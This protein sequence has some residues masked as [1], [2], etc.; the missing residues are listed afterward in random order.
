MSA[1]RLTHLFTNRVRPG[2][3]PIHK[4]V[5]DARRRLPGVRLSLHALDERILP[6]IT[7]FSLPAP[8]HGPAGITRGPDGNIWFAE[9]DALAGN[10][11]G[12]ISLSGQITEFATGITSGSQPFDITVGPDGNLWFT[13]TADQIG[14]I[15]PT[16]QVTEF[17]TGITAGSQPSG[18]VAGP[19]GNIWFTEPLGPNSVGA[20]ARITPTGV[21]TEFR[22]GLTH[23]AE[24]FEITVG[25]D[26]NLW[27]TELLGGVGRIT[28]T[29]VIT[30]FRAGITPG[31][32]PDGITA[33]PDGN[34]WFTEF[35]GKISRITTAGQVTEFSAGLTAGGSPSG[36]TS[37][38]D[39]NLWFTESNGSR[40]GSINT[41]G[42]IT[43]FSGG[44][45][46]G[47]SPFEITTGPGGALWF[48]EL[49][50][51]R[52]A[53]FGLAPLIT[54]VVINGGA[55]QRSMVTQLQ[56]AFD[57]H[58]ILP[59]NAADAF[60]LVRQSDGTV[61]T[62]RAIVDDSTAAGTIVMLQFA[63]AATEGRS[64]ADG[65]Y[66]LTAVAGQI[67]GK[68]GALDGNGDGIGGD[69]FVF[70]GNT[71]TNTLFR[72]FGDANGDGAVAANDFVP[73]R[74]SFNGVNAI[75]D[76]NGDG[77]VSANDFVEF[78]NRFNTS[79]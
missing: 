17:A 77:F 10:R 25:S 33:G 55:A 69:D 45:T 65:R 50:G 51:N 71:A 41:E 59:D 13:E 6:S 18:I 3:R 63:G 29:G 44:I 4:F 76:F 64:L 5:D 40:I 35:G 58:V 38:T 20:I 61:V 42:Q 28:T 8:N 24:P 31:F 12:R 36:I 22:T 2:R 23:S 75:F 53:R 43:E 27:F 54:S 15:S 73:F 67:S 11:I 57:Q 68:D 56:I 19:D 62:L 60:R 74:Q 1:F 72:L 78:R 49:D 66:T 37:G 32:Q 52:V 21:V 30:E 79:I 9:I 39:D 34:L 26:H 70:V 48:T 46:L 14:R 47:S 16:G 7:E